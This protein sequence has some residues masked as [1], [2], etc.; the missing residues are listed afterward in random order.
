MKISSSEQKVL[1]ELVGDF[2]IVADRMI[3]RG[4]FERHANRKFNALRAMLEG[5]VLGETTINDFQQEV[6]FEVMCFGLDR[7]TL[8]EVYGDLSKHGREK[9][10]E[11]RMVMERLIEEL[12]SPEKHSRLQFVA[13]TIDFAPAERVRMGL[14]GQL[15]P[16]LRLKLLDRY[17]NDSGKGRLSWISQFF[18]NLLTARTH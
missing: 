11:K 18:Y 6:L 8:M 5:F 16:S 7:L 15:P 17:R 14:L 4:D 3:T 12:R 13:K 10:S 9:L 1:H 2:L